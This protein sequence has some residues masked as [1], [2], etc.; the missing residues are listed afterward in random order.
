MLEALNWSFQLLFY[1]Y[2][3][4]SGM[5]RVRQKRPSHHAYRFCYSGSLTSYETIDTCVDP[6][7]LSLGSVQDDKI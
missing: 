5:S 7:R 3:M 1:I 2:D 6:I 4:I